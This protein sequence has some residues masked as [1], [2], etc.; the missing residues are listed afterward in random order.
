MINDDLEVGYAQKGLVLT[1]AK[2]TVVLS[3]LI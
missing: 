3:N 1:S 2:Q